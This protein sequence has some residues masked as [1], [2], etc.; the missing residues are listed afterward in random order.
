MCGAR[1]REK[2]SRVGLYELLVTYGRGLVG[3]FL[4]VYVVV[5]GVPIARSVPPTPASENA[6]TPSSKITKPELKTPVQSTSSSTTDLKVEFGTDPGTLVVN[7][8]PG[9]KE[10][11]VIAAVGSLGLSIIRGDVATGRYLFNL[12]KVSVFIEKAGADSNASDKAWINFPRLYSEEDINSYFS[13]NN[14]KIDRW[15][16][17][18]ETSDRFA[19]VSLPRMEATLT[20]PERGYYTIT[21]SPTDQ[22]SLDAWARESGVRII[23]YDSRTGETIVQPL[24]W[25]GT[26]VTDPVAPAKTAAPTTAP[27][28][29]TSPAPARTAP[30]M[31]ELKPGVDRNGRAGWWSADGTFWVSSTASPQPSAAPSPTPAPSPTSGAPA[32]KQLSVMP[33]ASALRAEDPSPS[34][35]PSEPPSPSPSPSET[36]TPTPSE[37]PTPSP[38]ESPSP[39]PSPTPSESP[40][41]SPSPSATPSPSPTPTPWNVASNGSVTI[42][43]S[44]TDI[45]ITANGT[46]TTRPSADVSSITITGG[47]GADD[48]TVDTSGGA[49]N[50]PITFD[51]G[52]GSNSLTVTAASSSWTHTGAGAGSVSPADTAGISFTGLSGAAGSGTADTLVGPGVDTTWTVAGA[53]AGQVAGLSFTGF[54]NLTGAA[55]NNDTFVF[56]PGSTLSGTI[57]GGAGGHDTLVVNGG[58]VVTSNSSSSSSGTVVVDGHVITYQGLEPVIFSGAPNVVVNL[59]SGVDDVTVTQVGG[60][61]EVSGSTFETVVIAGATSIKIDGLGDRDTVE[62]TGTLVLAGV[63]FQV[64]A[65]T[66]TV[67]TGATINTLGGAT[68]DGSI[69]LAGSDSQAGSAILGVLTPTSLSV[70]SVTGAT[71][72]SGSIT[73]SATSLVNPTSPSGKLAVLIANS[74]ATVEVIGSTLQTTG[75]GATSLSATSTVTAPM[76]AAGNPG[77]ST[78]DADAAV[79]GSTVTSTATARIVGGSVDSGA[80]CL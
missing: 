22:E 56:E 32:P 64:N 74:T 79:A 8:P 13:K 73:L 44:G 62:V 4:A 29:S 39:S 67:G 78:A 24:D 76:N 10:N 65:E 70:V 33:P 18:P 46:T 51:G 27:A 21:L 19:V 12:P 16:L 47:A 9:T 37:T 43:A 66:I 15:F 42:V 6:T 5:I 60:N 68:S 40:T 36:P 20:D 55:N 14:L 48:L 50:V 38:S 58:L 72:M 23:Q 35:S 7:F 3:V 57:Q 11:L 54:E 61:V 63:S 77:D 75:G 41:P 25:K 26:I 17:D 69:T 49:I 53:N 52:G 71:L 28:Q 34:P 59:T 2:G 31:S 30:P 45:A 1:A 80:L